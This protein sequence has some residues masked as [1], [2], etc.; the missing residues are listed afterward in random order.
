MEKQSNYQLE[1]F[2]EEK[3]E[4]RQGARHPGIP[5]LNYAKAYEKSILLIIGIII[6]GLIS[7]SLGVEKGKKI[8]MSRFNSRFDVVS[9]PPQPVLLNAKQEVAAGESRAR[10]A[11]R[12]EEKPQPKFLERQGY[13]IQLASYKNRSF[14][15]RE[16][17]SLKKNGF[18]ASVMPKGGF[19]LLLVGNIPNK[20]TALS[21]LAQLK[22]RYR[23]CY[24]R[25]L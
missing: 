24:I 9:A 10:E 4:V 21:M 6:T 1:L 20:E 17:V 12:S 5:F 11:V 18:S 7:F 15:E 8:S 16:V 13:V 3:G 25:R 22:K 2:S 19:T 23:D 14:A